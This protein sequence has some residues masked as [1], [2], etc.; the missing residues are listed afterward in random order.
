VKPLKRK[1]ISFQK[2][3]ISTISGVASDA[4]RDL[5]YQQEL[6]KYTCIIFAEQSRMRQKETPLLLL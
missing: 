3:W 5:K 1:S 2:R 6:L 4:L